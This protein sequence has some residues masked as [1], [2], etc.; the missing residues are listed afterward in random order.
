MVQVAVRAG[1]NAV[2]YRYLGL[3]TGALN[4][5]KTLGGAFVAALFGAIL[6]A[7]LGGTAAG[8]TRVRR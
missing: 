3:A 5:F 2:D 4:F 7:R 6:A 1:R 8:I